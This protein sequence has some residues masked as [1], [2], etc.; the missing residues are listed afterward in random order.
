MDTKEGDKKERNK[1]DG[2]SRVKSPDVE[3]RS[4]ESW[5]YQARGRT[6]RAAFVC[7]CLG[8]STKARSS[9]G[10][11]RGKMKATEAR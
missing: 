4:H 1:G 10:D 2:E 7:S 9:D 8:R 6:K 11:D 3:A 5:S